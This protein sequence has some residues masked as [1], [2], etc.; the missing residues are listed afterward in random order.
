M[1]WLKIRR[2][3]AVIDN[4]PRE[5]LGLRILHITD[6]H[7]NSYSKMNVNIWKKVFEEDFDI[8]CITG[9]LTVFKFEQILPHKAYLQALAKRVPVFFVDGN[10]EKKHFFRMKRFLQGIGITVLDGRKVKI[11]INGYPLEILGIRDYYYQE[12]YNFRPFYKLM[13]NE[14]HKEFRLLLSHQPQ[15]VKKCGA[16]TD[17]FIMSGHT[18]A[19]QLRLPFF[20]VIGAPGQGFW[21]KYGA[22]FYKVGG[23]YLYVSQ[24]IGASRIQARFFNR[25]E[26]SI[27]RLNKGVNGL[28]KV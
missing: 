22:G 23:N 27:I 19:G 13:K 18:H 28:R 10:H 3:D 4:L 11:D 26:V 20:P 16:F 5:L 17:I 15:I 21:P 12:H 6:L 24:G 1:K 7:N 14:E 8:A 25:P 2:V 9:D